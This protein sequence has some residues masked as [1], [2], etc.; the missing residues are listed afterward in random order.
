MG[1]L[2]NTPTYGLPPPL[3]HEWHLALSLGSMGIAFAVRWDPRF[4]ADWTDDDAFFE[5][6]I[7]SLDALQDFQDA[8]A[9]RMWLE[10][11]WRTFWIG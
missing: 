4:I 1:Q 9:G 11:K 10:L 3:A 7:V 5:G 8:V 6:K 2:W